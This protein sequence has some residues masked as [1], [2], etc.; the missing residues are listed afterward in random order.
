MPGSLEGR[1]HSS[2]ALFKSLG[3]WPFRK[4]ASFPERFSLAETLPLL[5]VGVWWPCRSSHTFLCRL[6]KASFP[7]DLP[8]AGT[9]QVKMEQPL[10]ANSWLSMCPQYLTLGGRILKMRSHPFSG[11]LGKSGVNSSHEHS[12]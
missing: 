9:S 2:W 4:G 11:S 8:G 6:P 5:A 3:V 7:C 1:Y 10:S 12:P